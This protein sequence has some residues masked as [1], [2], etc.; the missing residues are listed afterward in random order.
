VEITIEWSE[1]AENQLKN[2]YDYFALEASHRVTK[3]IVN[4]IV[5]RVEVLLTDQF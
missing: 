1:L 2:I 5:E 3:R 4:K